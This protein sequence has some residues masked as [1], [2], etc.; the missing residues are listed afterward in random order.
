MPAVDR[1]GVEVT[2]AVAVTVGEACMVDVR[3]GVLITAVLVKVGVFTTGSAGFFLLHAAATEKSTV[4]IIRIL[5]NFI[6]C[7]LLFLCISSDI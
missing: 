2:V 5:V 1:V 6:F 7:P 4:R 3:V